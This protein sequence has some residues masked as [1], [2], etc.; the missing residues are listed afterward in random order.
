MSRIPCLER[1]TKISDGRT[2]FEI[3]L[4]DLLDNNWIS[5]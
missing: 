1:I 3:V 4:E 2:R 5:H